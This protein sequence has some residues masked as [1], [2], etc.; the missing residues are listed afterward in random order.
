M[1]WA[2][3]LIPIYRGK[4][5]NLKIRLFAY[6]LTAMIAIIGTSAFVVYQFVSYTFK[7]QFEDNLLSVAESAARTLEVVKHE[8]D[9]HYLQKTIPITLMDL[10][11]K[12]EGRNFSKKV[13]QFLENSFDLSWEKNQGIEW[14]NDEGKL[15]I[16]EGKIFPNHAL[17]TDKKIKNKT[18]QQQNN[19][20]SLILPVYRLTSQNKQKLVGYIRVSETT[21]QLSAELKA[22]QWG[23]ILGGFFALILMTGS[24]ILLTR[25]SIKPIQANFLQLKQFTADASHELRTPLTIIKLN[26]NFYKCLNLIPQKGLTGFFFLFTGYNKEKYLITLRFFLAVK[27]VLLL[28]Q[29]R[30]F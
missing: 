23:L 30:L 20:I 21:T 10:T 22:L 29:T 9:E 19:F 25:E 2:T 27:L 18:Y 3:D 14:F 28:S 5:N 16:K 4:F 7:K 13:S 8:Y 17:L 15:L 24:G 6:Y 12:A 11:N 1:V 26:F